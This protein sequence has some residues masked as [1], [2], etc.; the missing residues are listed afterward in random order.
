M[1]RLER[2]ARDKRCSLFGLFIT[3]KGKNVMQH[4][5][6]TQGLK[7]QTFYGCNLQIFVMSHSVC[8]WQAVPVQSNV[9]G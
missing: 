9:C 3:D 1:P 5:Q 8:P 6:Q 2:L 7:Y 4:C